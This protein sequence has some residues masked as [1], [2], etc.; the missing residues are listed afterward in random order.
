MP[1]GLLHRGVRLPRIS[2]VQCREGLLKL[3]LRRLS[4]HAQQAQPR[5]RLTQR[6]LAADDRRHERVD[7]VADLAQRGREPP[8]LR[9][10]RLRPVGKLARAVLRDRQSGDE[11]VDVAGAPAGR[12]E[13]AA[14]GVEQAARLLEA[15]ADVV[16]LPARLAACTLELARARGQL[17]LGALQIAP[18]PPDLLWRPAH[19]AP[20]RRRSAPARSPP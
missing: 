8:G 19:L 3:V 4:G 14:A 10:E 7:A 17:V 20:S 1:P 12:R 6:L 11:A 16:G 5:L 9:A 13:H 18:R 2:T 15:A